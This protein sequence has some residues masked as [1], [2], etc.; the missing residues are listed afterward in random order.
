MSMKD[1][2]TQFCIYTLGP[3]SM[4][5]RLPDGTW[6]TVER[7][8]WGDVT[9]GTHT[10]RLLGYMISR[11][12]RQALVATVMDKLWPPEKELASIDDYM[13]RAN[14]RLRHIMGEGTYFKK[15]NKGTKYELADQS[16]VWSNAMRASP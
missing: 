6:E 12:S 10:Q 2:R 9:Y 5:R 15:T 8:E 4:E 11:P 14:A 13:Q 16:L 7:A 1:A 3:F